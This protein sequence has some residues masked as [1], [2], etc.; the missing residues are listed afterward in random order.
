MGRAQR[1]LELLSPAGNRE[2]L[3]AAVNSGADAVYLGGRNF[4]ARAFAGNFDRAGL[5]EAVR[6][7]HLRGVKVYVTVNTLVDDGEMRELADELLFLRDAR[8]DALI[9]QDMGVARLARLI[10]PDVPLHASTQMTIANS[11]GVRFAAENGIVRVVAAR[12][13]TLSELKAAAG[14]GVEIEA[15][16]HGAL[17][18]CYSGQCL[19]SSLIGGRSGNRGSCAQPCRMPYALTDAGGKNVLSGGAGA[20]A[21][22]PKDLRA[23]DVLPRLIEAGVSSFK[24]EGRMKSPE[25]VAVVTGVYRRAIDSWLRGAFAVSDRDRRDLE[26][27]FSRGFTTACLRSRPGAEM[28]S[29]DRPGSRGVPLGVVTRATRGGAAAIRL[30]GTLRRGDALEFSSKGGPAAGMIVSEIGLGGRSVAEAPAKAEVSV[31]LPRGARAGMAV[32]KTRDADLTA[33]AAKFFGPGNA[34]RIPVSVAVTARLGRPLEVTLRDGDGNVGRGVTAFAAEKARSR[35]LDEAAVR[36]QVGRLGTTA[37]SMERLSVS[38]DEGV[39][40]PASEINEARRSACR[41]LDGA[42][43]AAFASERRAGVAIPRPRVE[44]IPGARPRAAGV[45][46]PPLL[47]VW[48]DTPEKADAAL[49]AGADMIVFGGERFSRVPVSWDEY[50]RAAEL[51]HR[52]GRA[53]AFSTPRVVKEAGLDGVEKLCRRLGELGADELRVHDPGV[54]RLARELGVAVPLWADMSLNVFNAGSLM[55]W[56]E[57][58]AS[59][60]T[61]SIELN[62]S[63]IERLAAAAILPVECLV[64]G[65]AEMMISEYCVP[66]GLLGGVGKGP[67]A[68]RCAKELFLTDRAGARFPLRGDQFCRMHVL[69]SLPHCLLDSASRLARSGVSRLRADARAMSVEETRS[70]VRNWRAALDGRRFDPPAPGTFTR[71]HYSRGVAGTRAAPGPRGGR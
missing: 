29:A 28:M 23:L 49:R 62:M 1:E 61:L 60:A 14:Q 11:A 70:A 20:Y 9:V 33:R 50:A 51:T 25:Y 35:P 65:R 32:Y 48:V 17:C 19:M 37:Y 26:Q 34:R 56:K 64:H 39:I 18:V 41:E 31:A 27:I 22:S 7:A 3:E 58:G 55:F 71:G 2:S 43:L 63:Q 13:M 30:E 40:V 5:A 46:A 8:A 57:N 52:A 10:A 54:W 69:N 6:F 21:L 67:C 12:E 45:P 42:R 16:V 59:G 38:L 68:F 53:C 66:G 24:I 36:A 15:F 44:E 47:S 4:G